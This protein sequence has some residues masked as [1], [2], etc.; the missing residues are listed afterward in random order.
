[1]ATGFSKA[2]Q[3]VSGMSGHLCHLAA[4]VF[5]HRVGPR[6]QGVEQTAVPSLSLRLLCFL[7]DSV[8]VSL[9]GKLQR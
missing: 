2:R 7:S 9:R 4:L 5:P 1:M 3:K 6:P 8:P